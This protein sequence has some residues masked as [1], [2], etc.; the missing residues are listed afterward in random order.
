MKKLPIILLSALSFLFSCQSK[1]SVEEGKDS[2]ASNIDS[3]M[4]S[5]SDFFSYANGRWF[6]ENPIPA[7]ESSNGI[8]RLIQDT[9]N[10]QVRQICVKS[11]ASVNEVGGAKQKI[12]DMYFSGMD[13]VAIE[14]QGLNSLKD[15]LMK[16]QIVNDR[17]S[18]LQA[19][20][21]VHRISS[22]PMFGFYVGQDDKISNK[23]AIFIYQGGLGLPDRDY[24]FD[25]DSRT[26]KIREEYQK[27]LSSMF[28][29]MGKNQIIAT[30]AARS[31]FELETRLAK[32]SRK[33]EALRD[34]FKNY[35]KLAFT[36]LIKS[37][38]SIDFKAFTITA[39]IADPDTVIVGQ[40]EFLAALD[41]E[42]KSTPLEV[43]KDY[44]RFNLVRRLSPSLDS[45]TYMTH[46]NFY[47]VML[48]GTKQP[49]ARWKRVVDQT[50][51]SLGDLVG[52]IY[53][54]EYLPKGTKEKLT[55]IGDAIKQVCESRIN[56]LEWMS[57]ATKEQAQRK[58]STM[59]F[60]VGYPDQW[61]D[62]STLKINRDSYV[63]NVM[64]SNEWRWNYMIS[65]YGKPVDRT[66]WGMQP[67]TYNA[68][69]NP[70][71]NEIVVPAC[72]IIVPGYE[73]KM[74]DDAILYS[75]IGGSTFGHEI[76]HGFDD[77]GSKYDE[78]GNLKNWWT[79][80]DSIK[81]HSKT[82]AIVRQYNGYLVVDSLHINGDATQGENIADLG[83]VMMGYEAFKK[84]TQAKEGKSISGLTPDHRFFLAWALAWMVNVR[85][86]ALANEV[87]TDVH[88]PAKFRV[89]GPL[90]NMPEFYELFGVKEG[91][92]MYRADTARVRIW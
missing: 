45:K 14:R 8:F 91:D 55:E 62:M 3:T 26:V 84:T 32:S 60:K 23:N 83:G 34:P 6:K 35:N 58:L 71:N 42:I 70:S 37:Y 89:I 92:F 46:F 81:F 86:E 49:R 36:K 2:L 74:A 33:L 79:I 16:I 61:K 21:R 63:Q 75:I 13:T 17:T 22:A 29:L 28:E 39:G 47:A 40:P 57:A 67:Q 27:Y 20:A 24:Y 64:N 65:K 77:Q 53:V 5:S 90:S 38:P 80:E 85:P 72:N 87:K 25:T 7:S 18:L 11:A 48:Q 52:Q 68:Y 43:W 51:N 31:V 12:G 4:N 59:I 41:R 88:A 69:Y 76:T 44:L 30:K 9:I 82:N 50:N 54:T 10:A 1:E 66:E 73:R 78:N 15:E 56:K 19:A